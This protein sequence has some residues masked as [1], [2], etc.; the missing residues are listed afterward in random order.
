MKL[1]PCLLYEQRD[2]SGWLLRVSS[3]RCCRSL[4]AVFATVMGWQTTA[5]AAVFASAHG[6]TGQGL[7]WCPSACAFQY[8]ALH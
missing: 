2:V 4:S 1:A 3:S 6:E 7:G 5:A 8:A